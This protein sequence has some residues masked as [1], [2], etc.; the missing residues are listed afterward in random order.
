MVPCKV[1]SH[2]ENDY[3]EDTDGEEKEVGDDVIYQV[4]EGDD[5]LFLNRLNVKRL[6]R[7]VIDNNKQSITSV[8]KDMWM[9]ASKTLSK[10]FMNMR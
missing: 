9:L 5:V 7:G 3:E 8:V 4:K 6:N 1:I 10:V 2:E